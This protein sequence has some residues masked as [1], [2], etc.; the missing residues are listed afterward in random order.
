VC[1]GISYGSE[2]RDADLCNYEIYKP[3]DGQSPQTVLNWQVE[4]NTHY[5]IPAD[6]NIDRYIT[7]G[8]GVNIPSEYL[9]YYY[10]G[11]QRPSGDYIQENINTSPMAAVGGLVKVDM[12]F[13]GS[14]KWSNLSSAA[15]AGV[16]ERGGAAMS[17]VPYGEQGLLVLTG[18]VPNPLNIDLDGNP[19]TSTTNMMEQV[20]V[21]DVAN[22]IW[23]AQSTSGGPPPQL[24]DF[25]AVVAHEENAASYQIYIFG[26]FDGSSATSSNDVW[27]LSVPSFH[28]TQVQFPAT[29]GGRYGHVCAMPYPDQ[30]IVVG[31]L[32]TFEAPMFPQGEIVQV[33]N[34]STLQWLPR[35][36]PKIWSPYQIPDVVKSQDPSSK[37]SPMDAQL[38][39]LFDNPQAKNA[40]IYYPYVAHSTH[41]NHWLVP[42]LAG[43]L[44]G[45]AVAVVGLLIWFIRRRK[46][47]RS[48]KG[49]HTQREISET[50][51]TTVH[52]GVEQWRRQIKSM[53]SS[54]VMEIDSSDRSTVNNDQPLEA[55]EIGGRTHLYAPRSPRSPGLNSADVP[56]QSPHSGSVEVSG[57]PAFRQEMQDTSRLPGLLGRDQPRAKHPDYHIR[58]HPMYP[59]NVSDS[60]S[61]SEP[62][63]SHGQ[64]QAVSIEAENGHSTMMSHQAAPLGTNDFHQFL[65]GAPP[66]DPSKQP[67][68]SMSEIDNLR[69][70]PP[71]SR[72]PHEDV[73]PGDALP[74]AGPR[75]MPTASHTLSAGPR[76]FHVMPESQSPFVQMNSPEPRTHPG[77]HERNI[78]E[79][80]TATIQIPSPGLP[81]P[82]SP[83]PAEDH[84]RSAVL[85]QMP[86]HPPNRASDPSA[87]WPQR[88]QDHWRSTAESLARVLPPA[89]ASAVRRKEVA[90]PVKTAYD[91]NRSRFRE[92]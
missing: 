68:V 57:D 86:D 23:Y 92:H 66:P 46:S 42:V 58:N 63:L 2:G 1:R 31:G 89:N 19:S 76:T 56:P 6:Y 38:S 14:A 52:D 17:W 79:E 34:L 48:S 61:V 4:C 39:T 20:S 37:A 78:S 82:P 71:G 27:I 47:R 91:E 88:Q 77:I 18:G 13:M 62:G 11:L 24:A 25:C 15:A 35:Y 40:S 12:S 22:D 32:G 70:Y 54:G 84:R 73:Y 41:K 72:M 16:P 59:L 51:D 33:L 74:S 21:Y 5:T 65:Y 49:S 87:T 53:A 69:H 85:D 67:V 43:V 60:M 36:D 30:M 7:H 64:S 26:G 9:G 75:E 44:G 10:S 55:V 80:T 8:A 3:T 28:W 50:Q 81:L 29:D 90:S 45:V 83:T